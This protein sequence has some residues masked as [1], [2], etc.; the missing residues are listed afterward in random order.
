[1]SAWF[2]AGTWSWARLWRAVC[3]GSRRGRGGGGGGQPESLTTPQQRRSP[4]KIRDQA[5]EPISRGGDRRG[6]RSGIS[7]RQT[8]R[9]SRAQQ[10]PD[11]RRDRGRDERRNRERDVPR[12]GEGPRR[13][14]DVTHGT[15]ASRITEARG[16][17]V[18][19]GL[20]GEG[21]RGEG[22]EH[23]ELCKHS[24]GAAGSGTPERC[25]GGR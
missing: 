3:V 5:K 7:R 15:D 2:A 21:K 18:R 22:R 25:T 14:R 4:E 8:R 24:A 1:V 10:E 9:H 11:A 13:T 20:R 12:N 19:R 23:R 17:V 6:S 16:V